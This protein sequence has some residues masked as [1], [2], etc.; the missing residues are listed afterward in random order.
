MLVKFDLKNV[1]ANSNTLRQMIENIPM[2]PGTSFLLNYTELKQQYKF[3][4]KEDVKNYIVLAAFRDYNYCRTYND[5]TLDWNMTQFTIEQININKLLWHHNN[6]IFFLFEESRAS[7]LRK[8][9]K[10]GN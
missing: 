9:N 3:Y 6:R 10:N 8:R 5:Y 2:M 7:T 4:K 1:L